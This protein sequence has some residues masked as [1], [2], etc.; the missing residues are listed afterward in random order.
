[1]KVLQATF[2][3]NF[4]NVRY[5]GKWGHVQ[6]FFGTK[7][8]F[9]I[10]APE[11]IDTNYYQ[12]IQFKF[13]AYLYCC[14]TKHQLIP[15]PHIPLFRALGCYYV[16]EPYNE[17]HNLITK[18]YKLR[19]VQYLSFPKLNH[20]SALQAFCN[21]FATNVRQCYRNLVLNV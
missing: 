4:S 11:K 6:R 7:L 5:V 3:L 1:M 10:T 13:I 19:M 20:A 8:W 2:C 12:F 15:L 16:N 17:P 18:Q 21:T 9:L 14:R